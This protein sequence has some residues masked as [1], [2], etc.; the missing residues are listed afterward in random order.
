[1]K[2]LLLLLFCLPLLF[3]SC[4]EDDPTP[5]SV[6]SSSSLCG[7]ANVTFDGTNY[8]LN[9]P[10]MQVPGE[11][12]V[13]STAEGI[14]S[15]TSGIAVNFT[16]MKPN[17]YEVDW[18]INLAAQYSLLSGGDVTISGMPSDL[19]FYANFSPAN[20]SPTNFQQYSSSSS[21]NGQMNITNIDYT[22][23]TIDGDFSLIVYD[24][25]NPTISK[26]FSGSFSNIPL[27]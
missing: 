1:M 4:Q 19:G 22:N 10:L 9:N 14:T 6:S 27:L 17:N 12:L 16:N 3:S 20:S 26:S 15:N 7:S 5:S 18:S 8:T 23:N 21:P 11:C 25:I 13:M 24:I 2:K